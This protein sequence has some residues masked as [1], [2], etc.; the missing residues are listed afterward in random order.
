MSRL[1]DLPLELRLLIF[2]YILFNMLYLP[3]DLL[4]LPSPFH[5]CTRNVLATDRQLNHE[6][7]G[8]LQK[9][10]CLRLRP[11]ACSGDT[12]DYNHHRGFLSYTQDIT[13][14]RRQRSPGILHELMYGTCIRTLLGWPRFQS[15]RYFHIQVTPN[16]MWGVIYRERLWPNY[17][18][19][20]E[21]VE[22]CLALVS[23]HHNVVSTVIDLRLLNLNRR[24]QLWV[25][26]ILNEVRLWFPASR[27]RTT[28]YVIDSRTGNQYDC[29]DIITEQ[30]CVW[31]SVVEVLV[32]RREG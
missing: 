9:H 29:E 32:E 8:I 12:L 23:E 20:M 28:F 27:F 31:D 5:A 18:H 6:V 16:V 21:Y 26:M 7:W 24:E 4:L 2:N 14:F 30:L 25:N 11:V 15:I 1:L 19:M 13:L 22:E 3:D 17:Y 10:A